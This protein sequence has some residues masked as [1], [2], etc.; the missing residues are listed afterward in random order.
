MSLRTGLI[1]AAA[2]LCAEGC[3][4]RP[5]EVDPVGG[6][7]VTDY[8]SPSV[9]FYPENRSSRVYYRTL[10]EVAFSWQQ[11]AA[12][13]DLSTD[14]V[15]V[16]GTLSFDASGEVA[17]FEPTA[18]LLPSTTYV[19]TS[20]FDLGERAR[21]TWTTS[22]T[23]APV[24][25]AALVGGVYALDLYSGRWIS[26]PGVGDFLPAL[27]GGAP[28]AVLLSPSAW[29]GR[30]LTMTSAAAQADGVTQ[31]ACAES[32]VLSTSADFSANPAFDLEGSEVAVAFSGARFAF[33]PLH[34]TGA[35][36]PDGDGM[37]GVA[38]AGT[39]DLRKATV[40]DYPDPCELVVVAG[41]ACEPCSDGAKACLPIR[42]DSMVARRVSTEG[43]ATIDAAAIAANPACVP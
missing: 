10:I 2:W 31:D 12:T 19:V 6:R 20:T 42:T 40:P 1:L 28:L 35:F 11:A 23:G 39:L 7:A 18:P 21:A 41:I 43:L 36:T 17:K 27:L 8:F 14:D 4:S 30:A 25:A 5:P 9:S 13:V 37:E 22:A 3:A 33:T 26:P 29:D 16:D 38:I 15:P 32:A 24:N 34:L